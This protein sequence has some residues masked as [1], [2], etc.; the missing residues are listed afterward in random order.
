VQKETSTDKKF[1]ITQVRLFSSLALFFL[2]SLS[3]YDR[4]ITV[5]QFW[6]SGN[7]KNLNL[8]FFYFQLLTTF[9]DLKLIKKPINKWKYSNS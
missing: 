9:A 7:W 8:A 6:A 2:F 3:E 1:C 4:K 5:I